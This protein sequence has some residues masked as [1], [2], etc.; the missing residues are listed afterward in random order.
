MLFLAVV[1]LTG[2]GSRPRAERYVS[3]PDLRPPVLDV[4]TPGHAGFYFLGPKR[5]A[6]QRGALIVDG[7]GEPVWFHPVSPEA[8][9]FR[10]QRYRGQPV[11]TWW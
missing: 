5:D 7:G 9:D 2:C 8:T 3:R 4:D 11:L 6:E 1:V 10:V